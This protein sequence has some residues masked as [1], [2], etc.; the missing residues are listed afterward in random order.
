MATPL[1][2]GTTRHSASV[3]NGYVYEMGGT[4]GLFTS[5]VRYASLASRNTYWGLSVPAGT[6]TGTYT[7]VNTFTAV[8]SP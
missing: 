1:P 7:G 4:A 3:H 2:S 5:T 6:A 8:F